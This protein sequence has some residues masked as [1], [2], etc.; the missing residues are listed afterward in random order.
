V[1]FAVNQLFS[2]FGLHQYRPPQ[3]IGREIDIQ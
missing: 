1:I 3:I 2:A